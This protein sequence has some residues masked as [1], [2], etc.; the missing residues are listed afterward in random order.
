MTP[1]VQLGKNKAQSDGSRYTVFHGM[2]D[3]LLASEGI[4]NATKHLRTKSGSKYHGMSDFLFHTFAG[5]KG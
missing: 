3:P 5:S 4:P 1:W 2:A